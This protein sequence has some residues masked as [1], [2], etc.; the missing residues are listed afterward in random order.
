MF[1]IMIH[2]F[3][4]TIFIHFPLSRI[5]ISMCTVSTIQGK[6]QLVGLLCGLENTNVC[7]NTKSIHKYSAYYICIIYI[8]VCMYNY[9]YIC[10]DMSMYGVC[11]WLRIL[12]IP[13][14]TS[15][16]G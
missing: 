14:S 16:S 3:Q 11:V 13:I 10:H 2:V 7:I 6:V 9:I 12:Y 15:I 5:V 1:I 8:C 4:C